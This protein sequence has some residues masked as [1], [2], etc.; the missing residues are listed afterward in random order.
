LSPEAILRDIYAAW[1]RDDF[2]SVR[3]WLHPDVDWHSSGH[4]PGL[5]PVRSGPDEVGKW[6]S[7]LREPFDEWTIDVEE[8]RAV[9]ERIVAFV[10]FHAVGK[11]S[12]VRVNLPFSHVWEFEGEVVRR[13]W[14][15][16]SADDALAAAR[17]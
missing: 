10:C 8:I 15:F 5:D 13:Y 16:A 3:P 2:E 4:F 1:N 9:G 6:W 14:A 7:A 11:E 17:A 12:G